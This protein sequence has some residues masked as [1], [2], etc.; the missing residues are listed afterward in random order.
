M[1]I[2]CYWPGPGSGGS[3]IELGL[4]DMT[5]ERTGKKNRTDLFSLSSSQIKFFEKIFTSIAVYILRS[6]EFGRLSDKSNFLEKEVSENF[7]N[8]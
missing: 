3:G 7:K 8:W 1:H 5:D 4:S 6:L 2:V